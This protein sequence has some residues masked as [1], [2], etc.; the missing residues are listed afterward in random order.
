MSKLDRFRTRIPNLLANRL[1]L[2][3]LDKNAAEDA[4][5]KPLE[6][7]NSHPP[8]GA[9]PVTIE[10]LAMPSIEIWETPPIAWAYP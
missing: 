4:I 3:H 6:V 2:Q 1:R 10:P 8:A 7:Y 5:R 9:E